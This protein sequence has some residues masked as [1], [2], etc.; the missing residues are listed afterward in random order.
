MSV[1]FCTDFLENFVNN[2]EI[3]SMQEQI[4]SA[5]QELQRE[6]YKNYTGWVNL[7]SNFSKT[8]LNEIRQTSQKIIKEAE[9]FIVIGIG[10]SYIGAKSAIEFLKSTNYNYLCSN[11]PKIF[12]IGTNIS[13]KAT[14]DLIKICKNKHVII[15]VISKSGNTL[16]ASIAFRVF[17]EFMEEKYGK[18]EAKKR[19]I[20]TTGE[21]SG[22]LKKIADQENY[23]IFKIPQNIG[24]RYSILTSVGLLPMAVAGINIEKILKGA[25][26]SEQN[27]N[28]PKLNSN[29]CYKYAAIRNILYK[30]NKLIEILVAYEP[31]FLV[32][33]EWWKQLFAESEGKNGKGIFPT[34][35]LFT[36]DLHSIGQFIQDGN[37]I[38]F[39]TTILCKENKEKMLIP[40]TNCGMDEIDFIADETMSYVNQKAFESTIQAH[41]SGGVPN[42]V[43]KIEKIDEYNFGEL[44]YFFQKSCAISSLLQGVNPFNQPGVEIYKN[45]LEKMLK[46]NVI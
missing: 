34:S 45:N 44:V 36:T 18:I 1:E 31:N 22:F 28:N 6:I 11:T 39:E 35:A 7:P 13:A 41:T 27:F 32:F 14:N 25:E 9:I 12:F 10:G 2:N 17:K 33:F 3:E 20:C 16:E 42:C 21:N 4:F 40:N 5:H 8:E 46:N 23:K 43:I 30:K 24:G 38:L 29:G 15:N 19:I 26:K 37:K